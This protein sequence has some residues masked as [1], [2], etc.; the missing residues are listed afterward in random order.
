MLKLTHQGAQNKAFSNILPVRGL[1]HSLSLFFV[2]LRSRLKNACDY[3]YII[4]GP[5]VFN[6]RC[7]LTGMVDI[8]HQSTRAVMS[9]NS[10][11]MSHSSHGPRRTFF[12]RTCRRG[13]RGGFTPRD[14]ECE[15]IYSYKVIMDV[16][17]C[18]AR[19]AVFPL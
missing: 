12:S 5:A 18:A 4:S 13:W 1:C 8:R 6:R 15:S 3:I 9:A 19:L 10:I 11:V 17:S 14:Y 7:S 16:R 2:T